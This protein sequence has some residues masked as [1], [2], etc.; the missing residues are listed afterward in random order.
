MIKREITSMTGILLGRGPLHIPAG[1]PTLF[2]AEEYR[3]QLKKRETKVH[4]RTEHNMIQT[5][6]ENR[7]RVLAVINEKTSST[8][9]IMAQVD[10]S[11]TTVANLTKTLIENGQVRLNKNIWP[12]IYE[13][14]H[15]KGKAER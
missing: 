4:V 6:R 15:T 11:R 8:S 5:E 14:I 3:D 2:L 1:T 13:P 10:L 7:A 9:E 12:W